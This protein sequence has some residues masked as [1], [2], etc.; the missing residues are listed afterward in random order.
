MVR[1]S[2]T[3]VAQIESLI[4]CYLTARNASTK[5]K[6]R[7]WLRKHDFPDR[8]IIQLHPSEVMIN[9]G[10]SEGC[11]WK[12]KVLEFMFPYISGVIDDNAEMLQH[13]SSSYGGT[14]YL[15]SHEQHSGS[16][17]DVVC[18]PTWNDVVKA[19]KRK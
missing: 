7:K 18:C 4:V 19:T 11:E 2:Q 9:L 5:I 10:L 12:A 3:S 8:E 17:I 16:A 6:T 14:I 15:F 13:L 1:D